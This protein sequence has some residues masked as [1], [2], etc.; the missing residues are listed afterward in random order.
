ME[1]SDVSLKDALQNL[2]DPR[3]KAV[4]NYGMSDG[5]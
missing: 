4:M 1:I 3:Q 5:R 2:P